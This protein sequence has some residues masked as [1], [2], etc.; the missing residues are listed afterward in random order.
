MNQ[1]S[2]SV[3]TGYL[4]VIAAVIK[5][6]VAP[7]LELGIDEVYY[8][9]YALR[10]DW[11][12][13][14][15][16]PMVG[17]LIRLTTF[18]LWLPG[19]LS[20]RL[21]SVL[22]AACS[23]W[24]LFKLGKLISGERTGWFAAL[25]YTASVYTGFI[26]GFFI[27]PD[28]PQMLFWTASLYLMAYLLMKRNKDKVLS[29]WLL[30]GL[31]IGLATLSKVHGL[32]LWAG[33]GLFLLLKR[34]SWLL[35]W[36]LYAG[37]FITILCVLPIVYWNWAN[38]FITYKFH[39]ERVA[40]TGLQWESLVREIGGEFAYQNPVVYV[41]L[42]LSVFAL[43]TNRI[44]FNQRRI[45]I[46]LFCMSIPMI[47]IF[48]VVALFNPTLPH[49]SGPAFIPLFLI[50]ALY[51]DKMTTTLFPEWIKISLSLVGVVLI[52]AVTL[53]HYAPRNFGSQDKENYGEYCPTLDLSGWTGLGKAFTEIV[54]KDRADQLMQPGAS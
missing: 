26:A 21:G 28:T 3:K 43:L 14:D 46:W 19:E 18:N 53:V 41:L 4:I 25:L 44:R 47:L 22:V 49:W 39:S 31:M 1:R 34:T 40:H 10:P 13:F 8:W 29:I 7:L 12:Q 35:N 42:L 48:W 16:P 30:L 6:L 20:F 17:L 37:A 50:G 23:T 2:Y 38:N 27:L 9:T 5:L 11:N 51:L 24:I 54:Q 45:A 52:A 36:R 32:Y 15:H 33:F